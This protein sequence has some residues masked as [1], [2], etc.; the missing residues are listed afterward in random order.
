MYVKKK[1]R[2][3]RVST[4]FLTDKV[5]HELCITYQLSVMLSTKFQGVH[6]AFSWIRVHK[7]ATYLTIFNSLKLLPDC[8]RSVLL[9]VK[10]TDFISMAVIVLCCESNSLTINTYFS[11]LTSF[12]DVI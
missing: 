7:I 9:A 3:P 10:I 11:I 12:Y 2:K 6:E 8:D 4:P 5:M 1:T